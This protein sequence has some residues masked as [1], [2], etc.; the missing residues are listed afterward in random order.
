MRLAGIEPATFGLGNRCSILLS[1]RRIEPIDSIVL[2]ACRSRDWCVP[3]M[4]RVNPLGFLPHAVKR[5]QSDLRYSW[6]RF[7]DHV[8]RPLEIIEHSSC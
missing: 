4:L 7:A 6:T 2:S 5:G 1:Y 8:E 3:I